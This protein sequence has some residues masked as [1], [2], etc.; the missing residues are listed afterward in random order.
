[1]APET[2]IDF[3][4]KHIPNKTVFFAW[5]GG[6][7]FFVA[8]YFL[9]KLSDPESR[10]PVAPRSAVLDHRM[11]LADMGLISEEEYEEGRV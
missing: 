5:F 3:D 9:V 6:I 4:A 2:A 1:M 11:H 10:R 8:L 7:G